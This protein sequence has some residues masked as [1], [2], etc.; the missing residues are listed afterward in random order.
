MILTQDVIANVIIWVMHIISI[1]SIVP[2]IFLNYKIKSTRGLGDFYLISYISGYAVQLFYVYCLGFPVVYKIM[3][4]AS[5]FLVLI[6]AFQRF[7]YFKHKVVRHSI[8]LYCVN[9]FSIFLLVGLAINFPY[10][11]GH[12]AGWVSFIIWTVYQG[13]QVYKIYSKKSV[14]G[15]SFLSVTLNG[16][17]N[18]LGLILFLLLGLPVQSV[19]IAL[20]GILFYVIFCLQFWMYGN[21]SNKKVSKAT[22][23][24][25]RS[26]DF[27][28]KNGCEGFSL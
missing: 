11:I 25:K 6:L 16:F 8:R 15:F 1:V 27:G 5:F 13:P 9:F 22:I 18:L 24:I 17:G 23:Q 26:M 4:P 10:T 12:I 28:Q 20:G 7:L 14:E 2:Q 19:L 21:K 3:V